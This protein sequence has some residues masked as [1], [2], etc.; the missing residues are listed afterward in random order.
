MTSRLWFDIARS[1]RPLS[2]AAVFAAMPAAGVRAAAVNEIE[3]NDD[4]FSSQTLPGGTTTVYGE[5]EYAFSFDAFTLF[6]QTLQPGGVL[7]FLE[8][9]GLN[10]GDPYTV[11]VDNSPSGIDTLLGVFDQGSLIDENDDGGPFENNLGSAIVGTANAN[12]LAEFIVTSLDDEG[13]I[14]DHSDS[15]DLD[16]YLAPGDEPIFADIDF[17]TVTGLTPGADIV[18]EIVDAEFDSYLGVFD[19]FGLLVDSDDDGGVDLLSRIE[20]TAT[21]D[22]AVTFA[23]SGFPDEYLEGVHGETGLYE[24]SISA[25]VVPSPLGSLAGLLGLAGLAARRRA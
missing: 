8:D 17:Y 5:L 24:V 22:G 19:E 23:V 18:I 15:G 4:V 1:W 10:P 11:V 21:A 2:L 13:Y 16:I 25:A 9:L 14:G 6:S 12:G 20:A 3:G 7:A